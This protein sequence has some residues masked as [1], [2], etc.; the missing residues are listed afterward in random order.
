M[1]G[2]KMTSPVNMFAGDS[3]V[4]KLGKK[5]AEILS[6]STR[7]KADDSHDMPKNALNLLADI[8]KKGFVTI[9]SQIGLRKQV[10]ASYLYPGF[11]SDTWQRSYI[12]GIMS[13]NVVEEFKKIIALEDGIICNAFYMLPSKGKG[14][15]DDTQFVPVTLYTTPEG[16]SY[17]SQVPHFPENFSGISSNF[18]PEVEELLTK[19]DLK[20]IEADTVFVQ[21]I[22]TVWQ[23]NLQ[24]FFTVAGILTGQ[25]RY[26]K[27]PRQ[28]LP[29]YDHLSFT[30]AV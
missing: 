18:L 27:H 14:I 26:L 3:P 23:N 16:V 21:V 29:E 5:Q 22:D 25:I 13:V 11:E 10:T 12:I 30:N 1:G 2:M 19:Q 9:D 15:P 6:N 24:L 20:E 28:K 8:N 4:Q 17:H 7:F